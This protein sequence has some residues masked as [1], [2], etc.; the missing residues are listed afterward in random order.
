MCVLQV[1][2]AAAE[3]NKAREAQAAERTRLADE[4]IREEAAEREAQHNARARKQRHKQRKQ[5]GIW[6][7][8]LRHPFAP[9]ITSLSA[10]LQVAASNGDVQQ[11][12][13]ELT[14]LTVGQSPLGASAR[15]SGSSSPAQQLPA[16]NSSTSAVMDTEA[17][18]LADQAELEPQ[19]QQ[20]AA[21]AGQADDV[22][23]QPVQRRRGRRAGQ[24][25]RP[26]E[27]AAA[28][29]QPRQPKPSTALAAATGAAGQQQS[30]PATPAARIRSASSEPA[31]LPDLR[32][33]S[34]PPRMPAWS[35][36]PAPEPADAEHSSQEHAGSSRRPQPAG[37]RG[38]AAAVAES[39]GALRPASRVPAPEPSMTPEVRKLSAAAGPGSDG[40]GVCRR[41]V[42]PA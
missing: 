16:N 30:V 36:Q 37:L 25:T 27:Q 26:G 19:P 12:T 18:V 34:S 5:A 9:C 3:A 15:A 11:L 32:P 14:N 6:H 35:Q 31:A 8:C 1:E 7:T 29:A 28:P 33:A 40:P 42:L 2:A 41:S 21:Q 20:P 38:Q 39:S 23:F 13:A 10:C 17:S 24:E 4:L 22:G